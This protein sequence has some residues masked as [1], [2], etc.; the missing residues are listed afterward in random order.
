MLTGTLHDAD[1]DRILVRRV[2]RTTHAW[3]RLRGLLG[4]APLEADA[5][6][7]IVPCNSVHT[8]F[9]GEAIDV[10][11]IDRRLCVARVVPALR[12]WR[13]AG[14]LRAHSTLELPAGRAAAAGLAVGRRLRW[15]PEV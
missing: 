14:T 13:M 1:D 7:W 5:G 8:A 2:R 3:E 4:A 11:F 12:P 10:V 15:E 6:L 9:M